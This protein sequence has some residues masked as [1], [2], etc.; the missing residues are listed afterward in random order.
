MRLRL[1]FRAD[2]PILQQLPMN[3]EMGETRMNAD[4][5]RR[6]DEVVSRLAELKD[7]L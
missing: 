6:T 5:R 1:C 4:L 3:P 2:L 7:S